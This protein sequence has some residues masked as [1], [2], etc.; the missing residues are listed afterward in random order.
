MPH[1]A[2]GSVSISRPRRHVRRTT[3]ASLLLSELALR[4]EP[5]DLEN[6]IDTVAG[7]EQEPNRGIQDVD[8]R[9]ASGPDRRLALQGSRAFH[10]Q[11]KAA[12]GRNRWVSRCRVRLQS[13]EITE[14]QAP[15]LERVRRQRDAR[16]ALSREQTGKGDRETRFVRFRNSGCE[17]VPKLRRGRAGRWSLHAWQDGRD[18]LGCAIREGPAWIRC[19]SKLGLRADFDHHV[20]ATFGQRLDGPVEG[21]GSLGLLPPVCRVEHLS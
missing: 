21:R 2:V 6:R 17:S 16:P 4:E 7:R 12:R 8:S 10:Q 18:N 11:R 20:D 5:G 3:R 14:P 15:A 13:Q 1:F 9:S 19:R